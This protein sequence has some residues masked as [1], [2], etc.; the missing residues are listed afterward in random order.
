MRTD[1][2]ASAKSAA[3]GALPVPVTSP[4]R[5]AHRGCYVYGIVPRTVVLAPDTEGVGSEQG[6]QRAYAVQHGELAAVVSDIED[7][8]GAAS[9]LAQP[10]NLVVHQ[11]LLDDLAARHPVLPVRFGT[12]FPD[13]GTVASSLLAPG[14]RRFGAALARLNGCAQYLAKGRYVEET[15]L[16]EV[17]SEN[18]EARRL[19]DQVGSIADAH[20]TRNLRIRLGEVVSVAVMAKRVADTRIL[21]DAL[22]PYCLAISI[23]SPARADDTVSVA[24]LA[25]TA[26]QPEIERAAGLVAADW[27]GRMKLRLLGPMAPYDF[28][29]AAV[30]GD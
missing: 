17:L 20:A 8:A 25:E 9:V 19:R 27:Q 6:R 22:T 11:R 10:A 21:R 13:A 4:V 12:V 2:L 26:R 23:R 24:L 5:R 3:A 30:A 28:A 16:R 7:P 29:E 1:Q 15:V 14:H 18:P